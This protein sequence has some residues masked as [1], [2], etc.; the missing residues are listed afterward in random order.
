[1]HAVHSSSLFASLS[2]QWHNSTFKS[3]CAKSAF[4]FLCMCMWLHTDVW[5]DLLQRCIYNK[6]NMMVKNQS[7]YMIFVNKLLL[8]V[9]GVKNVCSLQS[10]G[11]ELTYY[12]CHIYVSDRYWTGVLKALGTFSQSSSPGIMGCHSNNGYPEPASINDKAL[13]NLPLCLYA[14]V[15]SEWKHRA[16][17]KKRN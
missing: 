11:T 2:F 12:V 14:C 10:F 1:M 8:K 17:C 13:A 6:N 4:K 3:L 15:M 7:K 9:S 16:V 5:W